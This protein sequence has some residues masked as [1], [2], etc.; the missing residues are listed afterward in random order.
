MTVGE[1]AG[2]FN[3]EFLPEDA[4]R[5]RPGRPGGIAVKNWRRDTYAEATGQPWVMPCPN[6]P[7]VETAVVYPGTCLFEATNLSEGRGTTRPFELIGAPYV[8]HQWAESL[9]ALDLP[10]VDFREA[11]FTPS[12]SKHAG[13][14]C[15]GV[16]LHVTDRDDFEAIRTAIAMIVTARGSVRRVR[17]ARDRTAVLDRP[18]LRQRAGPPGDRRRCRR[19]TRSWRSGTTSWRSSE[20]SGRAPALPGRPVVRR[21]AVI[22]LTFAVALLG[23]T[24][25]SAWSVADRGR[26]SVDKEGKRVR[27]A[28][29]RYDVTPDDLRFENHRLRYGSAR[30]A[31]RWTRR[32][33]RCRRTCDRSSTRRPP[34]AV[35]RRR[36]AG[37]AARVVPVHDAAGQA[38]KYTGI[39]T[40]L[41]ADQQMPMRRDTIF[42][43][44]SVTK[45]F[46]SIV[47]MQ[48]VE[49][50]RVDLDEP[51]A[52]YLPDFA[53]NGKDDVT[54]RHPLT[55]TGGLPAWLPL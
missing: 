46:T 15:A 40:Q 31:R 19:S 10:G 51:V 4:G 23:A 14:A 6:M 45:M 25:T 2:L 44:A 27:P 13:V 12:F 34:S 39:D 5:R 22:M 36:G 48:Q 54:V 9:N 33:T 42:D 20:R 52:T 28:P 49:A 50:G 35:R 11:Y 24:A 1:L 38:L 3:A 53:E 7:R 29:H 32:W 30:Q 43:L 55:H 8:D 21:L 18:A 17:L 47:V 26:P 37:L 16:Q 41:P